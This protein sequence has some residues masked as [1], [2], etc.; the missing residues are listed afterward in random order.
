MSYREATLAGVGLRIDAAGEDD[1]LHLPAGHLRQRVL[2]HKLVVLRGF[3]APSRDEFLSFARAFEPEGSRLLEWPTGPIMDVAIDEKAVNYVFSREAVPLHWDGFFSAEPSFLV[4]QCVQAPRRGG[5]TLFVDAAKAW[6]LADEERKRIWERIELTYATEKKAHYGGVAT[7]PLVR[8]HPISQRR[9]LRYAEPVATTL[10]PLSVTSEGLLGSDLATLVED[11]K[12]R[13]YDAHVCH[14]HVWR[15]G[16]V[17]IA[18]NHAL[19][20]GRAA[21]EDGGSRHLRRVQIL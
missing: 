12:A 13:L 14:E 4:F 19:L 16:D 8:R 3:R 6:D 1:L 21:I 20:H 7:L 17:A 2:E 10:N 18:D 5:A 9:T 15:D 11:L